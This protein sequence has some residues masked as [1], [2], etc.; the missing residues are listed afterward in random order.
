M[1]I[2]LPPLEAGSDAWARMITASKIPGIY[3]QS[4]FSSPTKEFHA[5][6]GE[7][8]PDPDNTAM[9]L[10]RDFEP[11]I[12]ARFFRRHP[13]LTRQ[14]HASYTRLGLEEWASA[15]PDATAHAN[16]GRLIGVEAKVDAHDDYRWT[17][18]PPVG[19]WLQTQWQMHLSGAR[20]TYVVKFGAFLAEDEYIVEYDR[21]QAEDMEDYLGWFHAN[22]MDPN[23][24]PP[25]LDGHAETYDAIRRVNTLVDVDADDWDIGYDLAREFD[26]AVRGFDAAETALNLAKSKLLRVMGDARRAVI[27]E[28]KQRQTVATRQRTKKGVAIYK[29]RKPIDWVAAGFADPLAA[30]AL[31]ASNQEAA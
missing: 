1:S 28:G 10:G 23:G 27:G 20:V 24:V 17:D 18:E 15:T 4:K 6:R 7:I 11:I 12:L 5:L 21:T 29:G 8:P 16:G 9:E 26:N 19:V 3:G 25:E 14:P 22:A 2:S 31:I 30:P 13:E